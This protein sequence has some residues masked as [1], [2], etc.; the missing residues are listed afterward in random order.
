LKHFLYSVPN[1]RYFPLPSD[2]VSQ[3]L[4]LSS[5]WTFCMLTTHKHR[6]FSGLFRWGY[7]WRQY[8]Y[9]GSQSI[10]ELYT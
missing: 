5:I 6:W 7:F 10:L 9:Q 3:Y 1:N 8:K 4:L 2:M